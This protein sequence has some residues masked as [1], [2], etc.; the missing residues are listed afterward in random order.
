MSTGVDASGLSKRK[1]FDEDGEE[2]EED[3]AQLEFD[4]DDDMDDLEEMRQFMEKKNDTGI[5]VVRK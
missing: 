4:S 1:V 2:I 5:N 3:D